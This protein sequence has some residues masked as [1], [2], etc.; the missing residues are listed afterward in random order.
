MAFTY[1]TAKMLAERIRKDYK[2]RITRGE[3]CRLLRETTN[4]MDAR[5]I[6]NFAHSMETAGLIKE[7]ENGVFGVTDE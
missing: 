3:L 7:V 5:W 6:K 2:G 4:T 1:Q